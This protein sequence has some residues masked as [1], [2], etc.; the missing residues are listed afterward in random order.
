MARLVEIN[1][2]LYV[3]GAMIIVILINAVGGYLYVKELSRQEHFLGIIESN[4]NNFADLKL[5]DN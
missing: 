5:K 3:V 2:R 1:V 4:D